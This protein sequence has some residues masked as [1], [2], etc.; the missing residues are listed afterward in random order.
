M[1]YALL[2]GFNDVDSTIQLQ[3]RT[4]EITPD[5]VY[6]TLGLPRVDTVLISPCA[7]G[8]C[9]IHIDYLFDD[10]STVK[11]Y[12]WC[13]YTLESLAVAQ[14]SWR[15]GKNSPFTGPISFL[16]AF[17]VD[18]VYHKTLLVSRSRAEMKCSTALRSPF[19]ER[20]VKV[21][22]KLNPEERIM[23]YWLMTTHNG[24]E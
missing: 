14:R 5:D 1:A 20:A 16:V 19:F 3:N 11:D 6:V 15:N 10:I 9:R 24:N 18:R 2:K 21:S 22:N 17:Y 13:A 8:Y 7:D 4:L 23:F 12:N